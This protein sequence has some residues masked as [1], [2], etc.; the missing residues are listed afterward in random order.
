LPQ[1]L[2]GPYNPSC[3]AT[4]SDYNPSASDLQHTLIH[5]YAKTILY[6][7]ARLWTHTAVFLSPAIIGLLRNFDFLADF[8]HSFTFAD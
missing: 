5:Q 3:C 6:S 4:D 8:W 1:T 2:P 7:I